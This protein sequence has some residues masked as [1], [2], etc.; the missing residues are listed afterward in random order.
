ME[1]NSEQIIINWKFKDVKKK[2]TYDIEK[3]IGCSLCKLVC[4]VQAIDLGPIPEIAQGILDK[5]NPKIIIDHE[6]CCYCMLC[7]II[8]PNNAF[9]EN[10][11]P[12]GQID[13]DEFPSIG[14]F[15]EIDTKKCIKDKKNEICQ[16]C[17]NSLERNQI[18]EYHK[19]QKDCPKKCFKI[20]S[21]IKGEIHIKRPMLWKCDPQGCKACINICPVESFYIPKTAEEVKKYGKIACNEKECFYC[22][23]C[24]NSCPDDLI[25]VN[26]NDIDILDPIKLGNYPWIEGWIKNIK[27]ILRNRL[28][29]KKTQIKIPITEELEKIKE[30]IEEHIPILTEAEKKELLEFN[31]KIQNF[32]KSKKIRYWIKDGKIDKIGL[33]LNR[34][35]KK[36]K[37][38]RNKTSKKD[39]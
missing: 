28:I 8:C 9:H 19:I 10:I 29:E 5:S 4:P 35:L 3:C 21:P 22:G 27:E 25:F 36:T 26:R 30:H 18:K 20:S 24:E 7:A 32:L 12:E 37:K 31:D 2:L 6:K 33:E 23:A 11:T 17:L 16:L 34:Y 14:K 13:L 1:V 38:K 39:K 15:Y